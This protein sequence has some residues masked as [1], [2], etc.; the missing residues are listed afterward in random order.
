M[1]TAL[2]GV[3]HHRQHAACSQH[4]SCR[5]YDQ[6]GGLHCQVPLRAGPQTLP[7]SPIEV[8]MNSR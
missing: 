2:A 7:L 1:P 5:E 4:K 6:Y 8:Q 3:V